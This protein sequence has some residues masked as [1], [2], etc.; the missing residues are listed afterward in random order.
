M[1]VT[2][3]HTDIKAHANTLR[4]ELK[5]PEWDPARGPVARKWYEVRFEGFINVSMQK[6]YQNCIS[7]RDS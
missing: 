6:M 7:G 5:C 2:D 3:F 1:I 4:H